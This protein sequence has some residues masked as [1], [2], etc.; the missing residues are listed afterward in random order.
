MMTTLKDAVK[1]ANTLMLLIKGDQTR[2]NTALQQ[3]LREMQ[4]LF[5]ELFWNNAII[6]VSFWA[7]VAASV[8]KRKN[9]GIT[10]E[11]F[12]KQWNTQLE[13]KFHINHTLQGVFIDSM[14]HG[15]KVMLLSRRR[16][17]EKLASSGHFQQLQ[18]CLLSKQLK[19]L[20][21]KM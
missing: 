3:M 6:G 7:Y 19:M 9:Q 8:S 10:E 4:A 12:I 18:N 17:R 20:W 2:F 15:P 13:E 5:G 16:S 1:S 11:N 21:R 14:S